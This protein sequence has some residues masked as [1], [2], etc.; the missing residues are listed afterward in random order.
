MTPEEMATKQANL[1]R[2]G[3]YLMWALYRQSLRLVNLLARG[4]DYDKRD[5]AERKADEWCDQ[6]PSSLEDN[7]PPVKGGRRRVSMPPPCGQGKQAAI[8]GGVLQGTCQGEL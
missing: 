8:E 3:S 4:K 6:S 1:H 7:H 5:F 2:K